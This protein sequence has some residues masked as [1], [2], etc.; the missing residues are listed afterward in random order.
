MKL[1]IVLFS[2]EIEKLQ[3]VASL[4]GGAVALNAEVKIFIAM[5]ALGAFRKEVAEKRAWKTSGEVGET[6]LKTDK[7]FIDYLRDAKEVGNVKVYACH[8][9]LNIL[10]VTKDDLVDVFDEV[11]AVTDFFKLTEGAQVLT[12]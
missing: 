8:D 4:T 1:V 3:A 11:V 12:I 10:G 7:T 5:N 6:L 2:G 9:S